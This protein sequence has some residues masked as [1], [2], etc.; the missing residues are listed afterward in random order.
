[1]I[2][3]AVNTPTKLNGFGAGYA[4]DLKYVESSIRKVA[5]YAVGHTIV[6]EKSTVPVKT[7]KIIKDLL[8]AVEVRNDSNS[9]KTFSVLSSPE[10][11]C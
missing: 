9:S 4:S 10:F 7:A 3:V 2:F 6:V 11:L 8:N 5:E 1:M